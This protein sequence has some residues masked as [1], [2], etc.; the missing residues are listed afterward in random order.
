MT[1]PEIS[2]AR[3]T[4]GKWVA[5]HGRK[6][7]PTSCFLSP[8]SHL[9]LWAFVLT[10]VHVH[11]LILKRMAVD[12]DLHPPRFLLTTVWVALGLS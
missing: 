8:A 10:W 2:M 7:L 6:A 4:E 5:V 12:E 1:G 11:T 9:F 3:E